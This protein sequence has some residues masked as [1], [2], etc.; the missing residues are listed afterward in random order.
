MEL[1]EATYENGVFVP[2]RLPEG[3]SDGTRMRLTP[4]E[5]PDI[6]ERIRA[7]M[8]EGGYRPIPVPEG[9]NL[10]FDRGEIWDRD[11]P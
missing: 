1:I 5:E 2:D 7:V 3:V 10:S 6:V 4:I 8:R 9:V 11:R